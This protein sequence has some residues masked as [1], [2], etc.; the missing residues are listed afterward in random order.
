MNRVVGL[1]VTTLELLFYNAR[2][3]TDITPLLQKEITSKQELEYF[4]S[5][6]KA[7]PIHSI[8]RLSDYIHELARRG[9]L[10]DNTSA[11]EAMMMTIYK[12]LFNMRSGTSNV[13]LYIDVQIP[14]PFVQIISAVVYAF[15]IQLFFICAAFVSQGIKTGKIADIVS[16]QS[17]IRSYDL[18]V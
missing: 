8:A 18:I 17:Y 16:Y 14:Y 5:L 6:P 11:S 3:E 2:E 13:L 9:L 15:L 4:G 10:G 1:C 12:S 7:A